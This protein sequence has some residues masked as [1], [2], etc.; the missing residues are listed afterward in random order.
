[1]HILIIPSWY[2]TCEN[3]ISGIFFRE[4]AHAL[5][6]A[7]FQVGLIAPLQKSFIKHLAYGGTWPTGV[8]FEIDHNIPTFRHYSFKLLP[9]QLQLNHRLWLRHGRSLFQRYKKKYGTPDLMQAQATLWA[10]I[11]ACQLKQ[12]SGIPYII[13]EHSS[14]FARGLVKGIE[15]RKA[16]R[17]ISNANA[18]IAVSP[19]LGELLKNKIGS[20]NRGWQWI[21]NMTEVV[22]TKQMFTLSNNKK[23]FCFL[24]IALMTKNKSQDTLLHAFAAQFKGQNDITLRIGGDGGLRSSLEKLSKYLGIQNQVVFLGMLDRSQ[25]AAE[26]RKCNA[27]VLSSH[28]ETFGVVL[29]EALSNGKPVIATSCGGPECIVTEENGYLVPVGDIPA[30]GKAMVTLYKNHHLFNNY[31]ITKDCHSNFGETAVVQK[32]ATLYKTVLQENNYAKSNAI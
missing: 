20:P 1:M 25:V 8:D 30:F 10:G 15:L 21:P 19:Q 28:Y 11:L 13:T 22:N 18:G 9:K 12:Q 32:I 7:G 29:I 2:P 23:Q 31:K 17:A 16:K 6:R 4:Q 26:M 24:N 14:S 3:A 5:K 27:F